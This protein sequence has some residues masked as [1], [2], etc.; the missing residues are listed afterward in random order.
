LNVNEVSDF[1]KPKKQKSVRKKAPR[2]QSAE[3]TASLPDGKDAAQ[4]ISFVDS[5]PG[6][7]WMKDLEGRY[8]YGN[9]ALQRLP[10]YRGGYLG[11]TDADILPAKIAAE[12]KANDLKVITERKPLEVIEPHRVDGKDHVVLVSKFPIIDNTGAVI[13]VGGSSVDITDRKQSEAALREAERLYRDIFENAGEGIFQT[14]PDGRFIM[15]NPA[16]ARM[17]G[18]DS[19][20]ELMRER[21]NISRDTY[22]DPARREEFKQL[23]ETHDVVQGFECEIARRD[24]TKISVSAN[25]RAVRDEQ[26]VVRYYEGTATDITERKVSQEALR[27]SEERY[28]D[29]VEHSHEFI[30]TH[31]LQGRILS[32]NIASAKA[33]GYDGKDLIGKINIR[34]ILAPRV[35]HQFDSYMTQL[36]TGGVSSGL[37]IVQTNTGEERIWEYYNSLRTAGISEPVVRGVA[38]DVTDQWRSA[39][40]LRESEERYRELFENSH[41]AIY[42]HDLRGIYLS[43]NRAAETLSG[44]T[45][46]E[47][48]GRHYSSFV[49]PRHLK[50]ARENFCR[51]LDSAI[52][53]T[54]EAEAIRKN[55]EHIPVEVSSRLI[56]KDGVVVGIQGTVRDISDRKQAQQ[57]LQT[58]AHRV[59]E[60]QE[61]ERQNIA[62]ELHDEIGQILTAVLL[63]LQSVQKTCA[64]VACLPNIEESIDVVEDALSRV[65]ELSLELRPALLDDLG[66]LAALRWYAAR[67]TARSGIVTDISGDADVGRISHETET[68]CF[69][70]IQEAL[71]NTARH[72]RATRAA[73]HIKRTNVNLYLTVRDNGIGFDSERLLKGKP[74]A[75]AL[76]LHGMRERALAVKG[77]VQISSVPGKGTHVRVNVPLPK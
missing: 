33:L 76:G 29:L 39:E 32:A 46:S 24:G 11:K 27:E 37:M 75:M 60:A 45:R 34:D 53:T 54:Y 67:Y 2:R 8:V 55:G 59:I 38:R 21:T 51:K 48:I 73:I 42:I 69:R 4:F 12:Y 17:H 63:N 56:H 18:F 68:A 72:S 66:L 14:T 58:Y 43:V 57:A 20:E 40:A 19:A 61:A 44:F 62:R 22:V 7:A 64:T 35:R 16:L 74:S 65:R 50:D 28:R 77:V 6:Y 25:A 52:E 70:I 71:T 47:I 13:M 31:D 3:P 15:A 9:A 41:E 10:A 30:C 36:Q 1:M 26:G 23:L 5:L 49:S